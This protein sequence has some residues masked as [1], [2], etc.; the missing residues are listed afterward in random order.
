MKGQWLRGT[1]GFLLFALLVVGV[2]YLISGK[3]IVQ[4]PKDEFH[5][6][7][8]YETP[9]S[10]C[11]ECHGE[12]KEHQRR[13]THPPKDDCLKCHKIKRTKTR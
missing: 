3:K 6:G 1:L 5:N 8:T 4:V 10:F 12:G 13:P 2:F 11:M 7:V 9:I